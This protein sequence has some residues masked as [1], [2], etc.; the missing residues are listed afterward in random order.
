MIAQI[1]VSIWS[2]LRECVQ[3]DTMWSIVSKGYYCS[4][5]SDSF[6][7]RSQRPSWA[8]LVFRRGF[9]FSFP[10]LSNNSNAVSG[11]VIQDGKIL[12]QEYV[13]YLSLQI[14]SK[15]SETCLSHCSAHWHV[16]CIENVQLLD[17]LSLYRRLDRSLGGPLLFRIYRYLQTS[18]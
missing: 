15:V 9:F 13:K 2:S 18:P 8:K 1:L 6:S 14:L 11:S 5:L 3:Q 16:H 10:F 17:L 7:K 12:N 4:W